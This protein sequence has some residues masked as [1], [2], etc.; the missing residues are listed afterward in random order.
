MCVYCSLFRESRSLLECSVTHLFLFDVGGNQR[1]LARV[2]AQKKQLEAQKSKAAAEK[3]G[4]KGLSL[5]A[6]KQRYVIPFMF[7]PELLYKKAF[8]RDADLMREKQ[9]LK[10]QKQAQQK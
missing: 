8:C 5:E 4:N 1:D 6:R 9:K 7:L 10:E 3:E 2:K